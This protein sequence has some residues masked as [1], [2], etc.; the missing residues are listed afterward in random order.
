MV[1]IL[2]QINRVHTFPS[3]LFR[4]S[5]CPAESK[6]YTEIQETH[7]YNLYYAMKLNHMLGQVLEM[8]SFN[9]DVLDIWWRSYW[10]LAKF[11][12]INCWCCKPD[13]FSK[14]VLSV[15]GLCLQGIWCQIGWMS[16][17][18]R[19][20]HYSAPEMLKRQALTGWVSQSLASWLSPYSSSL[21]LRLCVTI[22][23]LYFSTTE[24]ENK[25]D[26]AMLITLMAHH[27]STLMSCNGTSYINVGLFADQFMLFWV[28]TWQ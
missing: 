6:T 15:C 18:Q 14:S 25:M 1:P 21:S 2:N 24:S 23:P 26:P 3:Y 10:T 13:D 28:Y 7:S 9:L 16:R 4:I 20:T 17:P 22:C 19:M 12:S 8:T 11:L 27:T 5:R